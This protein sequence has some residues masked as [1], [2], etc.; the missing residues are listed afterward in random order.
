MSDLNELNAALSKF[1]VDN[2]N[3]ITDKMFEGS[4][5]KTRVDTGYAKSR[6][7]IKNHISKVGQTAV[8]TNDADYIGWLNF[9]T[10]H[11][12]ADHMVERTI[13]EVQKDYR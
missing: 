6:W 11:T 13:Q 4:A 3:Q 12:E 9:G 8:I 10:A 5:D 7:K 1:I 2:S